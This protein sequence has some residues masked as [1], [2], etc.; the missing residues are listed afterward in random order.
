[1]P[2]ICTQCSAEFEITTD[3]LEFYEK[4]S[5]IF[6]GK[7]ELIPPPTLCPDCRVQRRMAWR[8]DRTFYHRKS[9]LT[10]KPIISIY[11]PKTPF[12][13][14]HQN[15]WYGDRWDPMSYGIKVDLSRSFFEQLN[16]L[17]MK[18]PRL[19]M[20]GVNCEN[21]DYCNYCGDDKNCY[22][23]IAGEANEDC[24]FDLFTKY[25]KNCVD[26]TFAY[27]STL[28]YEC[29]QVYN[30]YALRSC[31]YM[32]DCSDCA[33]CFDCK[34]CTN[35]LLSTN[36]RNKEYCIMNEQHT[37]EE[38]EKKL[39]ELA[40]DRGSSMKNVADI[41]KKMRI[42]KGIYR[43]MYCMGSEDSAGNDIKNSQR[44]THV[45]NVSGSQDCKYLYDVLDATDCQDLNYSLYKPEVSYELISTLQM[46]FSAFC[47]ASHY[48]NNLFYCD[49]T[50][51]CHDCFGC[52]GLN[53]KQYC[54]LNT[55]YTKEEYE[56]LV[57]KIIERMRGTPLRLPDGSSPLRPGGA[58]EG[59]VAEHEWGEFQ[60]ASLSL[61]GYNET[62][63]QEY[64]PLT[65]ADVLKRGWKWTDETESRQEYA[66][67]PANVPDSIHDVSDDL[68]KQVLTCEVSG[69][70]YKILAQEL[71]FYR[72]MSIP[73][74]RRCPPQR[75]KD[76]NELRNPRKLWNRE[77]AK[78]SNEIQTTYA[79]ERPEIVYCESCYLQ[80]VY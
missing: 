75:H 59:Q 17:R 1:M 49:L 54:I 47:M 77:C 57:P 42:E 41:W 23:D 63:A 71:A 33:F 58:T 25:S 73:V 45:F 27:H 21:S 36:L 15:E 39:K 20:D 2:A 14:Y 64:M 48:S 61:F 24:Y 60:P 12:P 4:V 78:C 69:K 62:V 3:D 30:S 68:A 79:S 66:G 43:D 50:N 80:A 29:I 34:G 28:C 18:V 9:D 51:N 72:Q 44:C 6:N 56:T 70:P 40:L 37:K 22:L 67:P 46:R 53:R 38:Y 31:M 65:K 13:V 19:G 7:K 52:I 10:G 26:C 5:P 35:C 74:P 16:T 11:P 55:Q 32:E 8:N 76:R